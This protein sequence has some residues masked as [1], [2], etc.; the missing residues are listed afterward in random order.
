MGQF[1]KIGL[2]REVR[3][4]SEMEESQ[5]KNNLWSCEELVRFQLKIGQRWQERG[6][7]TK[8]DIFA[9]FLFYFAGF[10]AIYFLWRK[11]DGLSQR[12]EANHIKNLLEKIDETKAQKI[13]ARVRSSV[14]YFCQ[15][16]PIQ[17]MIKRSCKS[18]YEGDETEGSEI[19]KVLQ[20]K[21]KNASEKI[22]VLGKILYFVR[23]NLV[24]GS[25]E[26][27]ESGD[28]YKIIK[29]SIKPLSVFLEEAISWTKQQCPWE[30]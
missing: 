22:V 14:D 15:R 26:E 17:Q 24:H 13:L 6:N 23:C 4:M 21:N 2:I 11:I 10:N 16:I 27:S 12:E 30:R 29:K 5:N 8:K 3:T 7:C 9:K 20:D 18:P 28:D 1:G 19:K 25:K